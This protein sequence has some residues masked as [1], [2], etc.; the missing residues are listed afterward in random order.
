MATLSETTTSY[1]REEL[2]KLI[3]S[4]MDGG[5]AAEDLY[6][7]GL[8][9]AE[10]LA[11]RDAKDVTISKIRAD[12]TFNKE[13]VEREYQQ[14]VTLA[15]AEL[16]DSLEG[17]GN[18]CGLCGRDVPASEVDTTMLRLMGDYVTNNLKK[19]FVCAVRCKTCLERAC[20]EGFVVADNTCFNCLRWQCQDHMAR[21]FKPTPKLVKRL[22]ADDEKGKFSLGE[23]DDGT[24]C[25]YMCEACDDDESDNC[26]ELCEHA[27]DGDEE[28]LCR[29]YM[30]FVCSE[31]CEA[32]RI[33]P[34]P[35]KPSD[36][37]KSSLTNE[38]F[39][40]ENECVSVCRDCCDRAEQNGR[41]ED[42]T[43]CLFCKEAWHRCEKHDC[44]AKAAPSKEKEPTVI[45]IDDDDEEVG[46]PAKRA[47]KDDDDDD[48]DVVILS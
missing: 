32:D 26:C 34:Y 15:I 19:P 31:H 18:A 24:V 46:P 33:V 28:P 2:A 5:A 38:Y 10:L 22:A 7:K 11:S 21:S 13:D 41:D 45:V 44:A 40:G 29:H 12:E 3:E 37:L 16:R 17:V 20:H 48:D 6:Y 36:D 30:C 27:W 42:D 8:H 23:D 9:G 35:L 14:A 4:G 43:Y 39:S 1:L 47:R 25:V